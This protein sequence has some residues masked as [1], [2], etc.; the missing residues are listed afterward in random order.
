MTLSLNRKI[1]DHF[2]PLISIT[3]KNLREGLEIIPLIISCEVF[4]QIFARTALI[5]EWPL[6]FTPQIGGL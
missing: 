3:K 5:L 4:E 1:K 2:G 6:I